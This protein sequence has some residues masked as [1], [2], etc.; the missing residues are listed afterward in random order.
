MRV[1]T[2][3]LPASL[4]TMLCTCLLV[5]M[6]LPGMSVSAA[7]AN[8]FSLETSTALPSSLS[9]LI[10]QS[11]TLIN[12]PAGAALKVTLM[13]G[14]TAVATSTLTFTQAYNNDRLVPAV[15]IAAFYPSGSGL[16]SGQ[17]LPGS[18]LTPGFTNLDAL[19]A[20]LGDYRLLWLLTEGV[21]ATPGL[22]IATSQTSPFNPIDLRLRAVSAAV[23][24]GDQKPG[25]VLFYPRYTSSVS[26]PAR[27]DSSL[28]VAN[29]SPTDLVYVRLFLVDSSCQ[30]FAYTVC[31]SPNQ[32]INLLA[33]D[34]DPGSR[35]YVVAV[36]CNATG[37]PIQFN[38]LTGNVTVKQ[39]NPVNGASFDATLSAVACAKRSGGA[40]T[41]ASGMA[42]LA[43]DDQM[44]DRLPEQIA[45]DD[46]PSQAGG[47]NNTTLTLLRP[48]PVLSGGSQTVSYRVTAYNNTGASASADVA[49]ACYRDIPLTTLRTTPR[50]TDLIPAGT[51]GWI[52]ASTTD[53][54]PLLGA[55]FNYGRFSSGNTTRAL[56]YAADYRITVPVTVPACQ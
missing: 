5:F 45:A 7:D 31:L 44:Y 16:G 13:K 10:I 37:Q 48:L 53:H 43:F 17:P 30:A 40:V 51:G 47:L 2:A 49:A 38:W 56:S 50:I 39:P 22:A 36:A 32:T 3:S 24:P 26:N 4:R 52:S 27:E 1:I 15:S 41:V 28:S 42:E 23:R 34:I 25:S 9:S 8:Y 6:L 55:Q 21:I 11:P 18:T 46:I 19:A 33:S 14:L 54:L 20:T 12:V 29:T 35:G